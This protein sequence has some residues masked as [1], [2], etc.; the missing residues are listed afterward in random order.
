MSNQS[1]TPVTLAPSQSLLTA[2]SLSC[3]LL[4]SDEV[5][6][7]MAMKDSVKEAGHWPVET[8]IKMLLTLVCTRQDL[9]LTRS[10][11]LT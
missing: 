2:F 4:S 9:H 6:A 1:E 5:G 11:W 3:G 7:Q 10:A 8:G